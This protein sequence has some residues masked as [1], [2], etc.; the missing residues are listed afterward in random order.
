MNGC[1]KKISDNF[2]VLP[3]D[4]TQCDIVDITSCN[5]AKIV[6]FKVM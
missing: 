4:I 2:F 5:T 6:F 3:G 1:T